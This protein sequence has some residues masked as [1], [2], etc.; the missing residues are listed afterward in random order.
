M[1][2]FIHILIP[3]WKLRILPISI[4]IPSQCQ[5]FP[6][7]QRRVQVIPTDTGLFAISMLVFC[8]DVHHVA[9]IAPCPYYRCRRF[10]IVAATAAIASCCE[11]CWH[12]CLGCAVTAPLPLCHCCCDY[13]VV[14]KF[15]T[16]SLLVL[17]SRYNHTVSTLAKSPSLLSLRR[18]CYHR[19]SLVATNWMRAAQSSANCIIFFSLETSWL[20]TTR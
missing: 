19:T 12:C 4:L 3:S 11:V 15:A 13:V 10:T 14:G 7:K 18:N 8:C 2:I 9:T 16:M 17:R 1:Y 5:N 6:S 20:W